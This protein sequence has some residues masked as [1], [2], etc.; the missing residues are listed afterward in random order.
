MS[1]REGVISRLFALVHALL[2]EDWFGRA[3]KRFDQT[4]DAISEFA[5]ENDIRPVD[6]AREGVELVRTT[7]HGK[8]NKDMAAAIRDFTEAEHTKVETELQK[9]SAPSE[10]RKNEAE[11]RLAEL[12]VLHSEADLLEK[13]QKLNV[14]L[15]RDERGNLT[16]LPAPKDFDLLELARRRLVAAREDQSQ[17]VEGSPSPHP[18]PEIRESEPAV[19]EDLILQ[20]EIYLQYAMRS[21]ALERLGRINQFFPHEEAKNEK[22]RQLYASAEFIPTYKN[23]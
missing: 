1:R 18:I 15:R 4:I 23:T 9:R 20:A 5:E 16:V 21:K 3:G 14:A 12:Q 22:L 6:L 8:A 7:L 13:L 10:V 2:P 17:V 11:A 19:L